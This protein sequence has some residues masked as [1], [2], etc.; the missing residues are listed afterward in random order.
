MSVV[1][2]GG[3]VASSQRLASDEICRVLKRVRE[4]LEEYGQAFEARFDI[5]KEVV[6]RRCKE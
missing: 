2:S 6:D 1:S 5:D 4:N 3:M